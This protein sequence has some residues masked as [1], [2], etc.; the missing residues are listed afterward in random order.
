MVQSHKAKQTYKNNLLINESIAGDYADKAKY[1][2][3]PV[4]R[5]F[6]QQGHLCML[7]TSAAATE[8]IK[9]QAYK[10]GEAGDTKQCRLFK[11]GMMAISSLI[12]SPN[13]NDAVHKLRAD[14][15]LCIN[16]QILMKLQS[17]AILCLTDPRKAHTGY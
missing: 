15:Q 3:Q 9:W 11:H 5:P 6:W 1:A 16:H 12:P 8:D 4:A 13:L 10:R 17:V 2:G 14:L 7:H